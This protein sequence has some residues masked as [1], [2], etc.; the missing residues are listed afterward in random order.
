MKFSWPFSPLIPSASSH[1]F[2]L[3]PNSSLSLPHLPF[4][5]LS[6]STLQLSTRHCSPIMKL[7]AQ[8]LVLWPSLLLLAGRVAASSLEEFNNRRMALH[9][10]AKRDKSGVPANVFTEGCALKNMK[11]VM[12]ADGS[13]D[14]IQVAECYMNAR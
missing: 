8:Y 1:L 2:S 9:R 5:P 7:S 4:F 12:P 6:P 11:S 10:I 3:F 13:D 14:K